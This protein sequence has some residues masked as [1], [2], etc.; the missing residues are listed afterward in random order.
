[1]LPLKC[2]YHACELQP[3]TIHCSV[4]RIAL[5]S[6]DRARQIEA[7]LLRLAQTGQLRGRVTEQQL[8]DL[9]EQA[10]IQLLLLCAQP[11]DRID[12]LMMLSRRVHQRK[13]RSW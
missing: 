4:S 1:M 6:T 11:A 8:I 9:L 10:S 7:M 13:G 12:R 5:V 2:L 3:S